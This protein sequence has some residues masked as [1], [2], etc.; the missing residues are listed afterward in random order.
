M[1]FLGTMITVILLAE[2]KSDPL[3]KLLCQRSHS[4]L[5]LLG[6]I[7][8]TYKVNRLLFSQL[9]LEQYSKPIFP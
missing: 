9:Q 8:I 7:S 1:L 3:Y 2:R 6:I 4:S 5:K